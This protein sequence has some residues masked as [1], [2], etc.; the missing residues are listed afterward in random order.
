MVKVIVVIGGVRKAELFPE[1]MTVRKA[2]E[3]FVPEYIGSVNAVNGKP[4]PAEFPD[5]PLC[6]LAENDTVCL[7]SL[8]DIAPDMG[9]GPDMPVIPAGGESR[10]GSAT[11]ETD[12]GIPF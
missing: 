8:G 1:H 9:A 4:R 7:G 3:E 2:M 5:Q 12:S 10:P 6:E 11:E